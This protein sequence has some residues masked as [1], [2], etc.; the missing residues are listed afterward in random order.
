LDAEATI[1][2]REAYIHTPSGGIVAK[3][4]HKKEEIHRFLGGF[5]PYFS[6]REAKT[7]SLGKHI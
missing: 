1:P 3:N 6:N 2:T 7:H 4:P 5:Q